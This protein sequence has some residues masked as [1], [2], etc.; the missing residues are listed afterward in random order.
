M[1]FAQSKAPLSERSKYVEATVVIFIY[2]TKAKKAKVCRHS[3]RTQK[4]WKQDEYT[5]T[6]ES[7][8]IHMHASS[9]VSH[10][11]FTAQSVELCLQGPIFK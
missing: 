7:T 4:T 6:R 2:Y 10:S 1:H 9:M 8:H 3:F 5:Y 11:F